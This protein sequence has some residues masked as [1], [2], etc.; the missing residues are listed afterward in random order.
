LIKEGIY[1]DVMFFP[2]NGENVLAEDVKDL[3]EESFLK[4][5]EGDKKV[6]LINHGETM[7]ASAQNKILKT[8][9]EPPSGVHIL[10]GATSEFPLLPTVKSRVKRLEIPEFSERDIFNALKD[11]C[12]DSERLYQAIACGDGT[13]GKAKSLY[14]D[15]NLSLATDSA[16]DMLINMKSSKDI[17]TYAVKIENGD[18]DIEEFLSVL[19]L[20]FRDMTLSSLGKEDK[21]KNP[22]VYGKLKN[23]EGWTPGS[24]LYG[25]EKIE[26]AKKKL[27]FNGNQNIVLERLLFQILE[28]KYKWRK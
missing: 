21:V 8:L 1:Q 20:I 9:E 16:V 10:I 15:E 24:I 11:E 6:F 18:Y 26:E 23:A 5:I 4:P 7:N 17:L 25:I 3:I 27:K 12:T 13:I 2:K 19:E 22:A 28:G 14:G